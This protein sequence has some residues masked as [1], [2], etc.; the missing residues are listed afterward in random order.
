MQTAHRPTLPPVPW[1]P[2]SSARSRARTTYHCGAYRPHVRM[3]DARTRG[4]TSAR[5]ARTRSASDGGLRAPG[6]HRRG[7]ARHAL[8][9]VRR[10]TR[11]TATVRPVVFTVDTCLP[12]TFE[13]TVAPA[14]PS[15]SRT[16]P[17]WF[18]LP[19]PGRCD[20]PGSG[21]ATTAAT[22]AACLTVPCPSG[23]SKQTSHGPFPSRA[24]ACR[25]RRPSYSWSSTSPAACSI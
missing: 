7:H 23:W 9:H 4:T 21:S 17:W 22:P 24:T 2:I 12:V 25:G 11:G 18:P 15:P 8:C 3:Q 16:G 6:D 19:G 20:W 1:Q 5:C 13:V 14:P 10:R